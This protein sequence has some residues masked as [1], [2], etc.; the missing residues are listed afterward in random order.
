[1]DKT[2][3]RIQNKADQP[4]DVYLYDDIGGYGIDSASFVNELNAIDSSEINVR[5]NSVGGEVFQGFAIYQ[6]LRE[7]KADVNV[8][9]DGI[10]ASIASVIAM[11]GDKVT[12]AR[13]AQMMIHDGHVAVQGNAA[14]LSKMVE[15]LDRASNNIASVY[16]E[17]CGGSVEDWRGAMKAETWYTAE[18]AVAAGLADEIVA[19]EKRTARN[20]S[21]LRIFNYAGREFAPAPKTFDAVESEASKELNIDID[22]LINSIKKGLEI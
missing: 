17:R 9:V 5:I 7:H 8:F 21:D 22:S 16:A 12:M 15:L 20:V 14:D 10:A 13:N 19:G 2:W 11:A 6:A 4:T 1:M 3:Y 18:E